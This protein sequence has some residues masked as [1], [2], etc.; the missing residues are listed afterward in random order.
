[1]R[2][3]LSKVQYLLFALLIFALSGC[4]ASNTTTA[5]IDKA[6]ASGKI[7]ANLVLPKTA[8]KTVALAT[9]STV[10]LK[11]TGA[12]IPTATQDFAGTTGGTLDVYPG[13]QLTVT[14]QSLGTD[15]AVVLEG[16]ASNVTVDAGIASNVT[17][18]MSAPVVKAAD[19]DCLNCHDATR[20]TDKSNLVANYKQ[21]GHYFNNVSTNKSKFGAKTAGCAGCHGTQHN[22]LNPAASGRCFECHAVGGVASGIT[23]NHATYLGATT[24]NCSSCHIT[25]NFK[26]AT[27][28]CVGCHSIPQN[29][30]AG[31]VQDNNG[32]RSIAQEFTKWSHHVTGVA[33]NDA[34]C[35]AC[36]LEG[37]VSNGKVVVDA[38]VHMS[39]AQ[40]HLRNADTDADYAWDPAAPNHTNMDNF[41]MSCHD[42]NGATSAMS[43]QIQAYINSKGLFAAGK[44]A[45]PTNPFG[46][47]ISNRYDKMQRPA[48][49]DASS[50][51]NTTNNSHHAVKGPR[52]SGRTRTAG[53]RQ[54]ASA[55]TFAA[56]SSASLYG[57][58]S[59]IYD[60]GNFNQLYTPLENAAGEVAPRTGSE[61]LGD[62][63]TLH[64][65]DCHTVGQWKVGSSTTALGQPT[66]AAIGAH[67]SSNEYLLRNTLG[68][69]ERHTQ[70]AY[71]LTAG[72]VTFTN[73]NGA[74]LVCYN[75][76]S[77]SKYGS[78]FNASGVNASSVNKPHAG[79]YD[80]AGRCDG[81]G[82]TLPFNGYTTGKATDGTQFMSRLEGPVST[83][84]AT[85]AFA[86]GWPLNG[87]APAT[88]E[89]NPDY[90]NIFGI[91]CNNCHNSG[92]GNGYGGIHGS[93]N[94][95][96]ATGKNVNTIATAAGVTVNGGAYIDGMGNV[97][98]AM[99]F[100]PGLGNVMYVPGTIAGFTGGTDTAFKNGSTASG[101]TFRTG[102]VNND[103]NWEQ[104]VGSQTGSYGAGCYT[105]RR[106]TDSAKPVGTIAGDGTNGQGPSVT[107]AGGAA[108]DVLDT[109][110]ACDDH[111]AIPGKGTSMIKNIV[112]PVT[113]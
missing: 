78:V 86:S 113:Y 23:A 58:R 77:Y 49:V 98:K 89:Q 87:T 92:V 72:I 12:T 46:D 4:G 60:A 73:P 104:K 82:N 26:L 95:T 25:H 51:F 112:R 11:V 66:P 108:T 110:G 43:V 57:V 101:G 94:N 3:S 88:G 71:T 21:S 70:N 36:H 28:G 39:D 54:I 29:A 8:G 83:Y 40:T 99:R 105:L 5:G 37:K 1:M 59:T 55:A 30:G 103:T 53:A 34:H 41:C 9:V 16:L 97:T 96:N 27:A 22:D 6:K 48:V 44:T 67:G 13:R 68:T 18:T 31:Y 20:D 85:P 74:F 111:N 15:G 52:Y 76:H 14:A 63:S 10:R 56:N 33:L 24:N 7:T 81:I 109:W 102:G 61:T 80:Q 64:C 90:G 69:D 107:G 35:A 75:C 50:Q 32:V 93:A 42:N 19:A 17:I 100:L 45:S 2:N 84:A 79:E 38:A 65:G 62:D 106:T 91:Q 47:T